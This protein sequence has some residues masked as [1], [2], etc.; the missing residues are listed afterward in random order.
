M[1]MTIKRSKRHA[2]ADPDT[3]L[4]CVLRDELG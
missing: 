3:P 4:V 1:K 2:D